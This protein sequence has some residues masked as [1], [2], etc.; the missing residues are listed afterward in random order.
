MAYKKYIRRNGKIYGPYIYHSKRI[1][2]KVVS[3]YQGTGRKI[4]YKKFIF[5]FVGVLLISVLIYGIIS[6]RPRFTG[7]VVDLDAQEFTQITNLTVTQLHESDELPHKY[8]LNLGVISSSDTNLNYDWEVD[9]GYFSEN[10]AGTAA[11]YSG[12]DK[13]IEWYTTGECADAMVKVSVIG[14]NIE[15]ELV[16]SVFAPEDR[17]ITDINLIP[18]SE[19]MAEES[20]VEEDDTSESDKIDTINLEV[21]SEIII[22]EDIFPLSDAEKQ[23]LINEFE[24]DVVQSEVKLFN[25]RIIARSEF[26]GMWVENS[27][28]VGLSQLELESQMKTDRIRWLRDIL[29]QFLKEKVQEQGL[30]GF[31]E[32]YPIV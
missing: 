6:N 3:E 11:E 16:Q 27:Y 24:T 23:I 25:G 2:D 32:S 18:P 10:N 26:S 19:N 21:I 12:G 7:N 14:T 20:I 9:C 17:I 28:D 5:I 31:E 13:I 15:Q 30:E 4:D 1:G 22:I 29:N 8:E